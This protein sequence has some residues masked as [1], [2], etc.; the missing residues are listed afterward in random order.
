VINRRLGTV[1]LGALFGASVVF[2]WLAARSEMAD[3]TFALVV[4]AILFIASGL[5]GALRSGAVAGGVLAGFVAGLLSAL[6]VPGDYVLFH[7]AP[8]FPFFDVGALVD[9]MAMAAMAVM[10]LATAGA[11]L[12]GLSKHRNR[13]GRSIRAFVAAWRHDP[14]LVA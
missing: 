3:T 4:I 9:T 10:L 2:M 12:P 13:V 1:L 5:V 14:K 7:T 6:T 11:L 8:Y